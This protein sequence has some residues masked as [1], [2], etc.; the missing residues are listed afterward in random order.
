[1][2]KLFKNYVENETHMRI[3]AVRTDNIRDYVNKEFLSFLKEHDF[4]F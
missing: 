2:F 1:M 4:R 3:K